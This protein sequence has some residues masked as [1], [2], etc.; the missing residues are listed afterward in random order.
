MIPRL[1]C[2]MMMMVVV[3]IECCRHDAGYSE[4]G[5]LGMCVCVCGCEEK[6]EGGKC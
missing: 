1:R 5:V 3:M 2:V 6:E 4:K